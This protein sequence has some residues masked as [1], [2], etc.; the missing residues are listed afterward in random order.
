MKIA[1]IGGVAAGTSAAAKARRTDPDAEI[2]LFEKDNDISYAGC[3]LPYYI[4]DLIEER[5]A[6]V[7]NTPASFSERYNVDVKTGHEVTTINCDENI[8][9]VKDLANDKKIRYEYDK[10]IVA[11]GASPV[12]PPIPGIDLNNIFPLRTVSDADQI[13]E[14][15]LEDNI[16]KVAVIGA[17]LIGLEMVESFSKLAKD[18]SVIEM[19]P[20]VLPQF[21][22]EMA[23]IVEKHLQDKGVN[24]ILADGVKEFI[25]DEKVNK[26]ITQSGQEIEVD[27]VLLSIGVKPVVD[28]AEESGI[29]LGKTGAIAVDSK[30]QTSVEHIYA[31]GDCA[32]SKD[33]LTEKPVW[34]P[35]GSTANKQGRVAGENAAGGNYEHLG[36]LKTGITKIFD[37]TVATTGLNEEEAAENGFEPVSVKIRAHHHAGY[38]PGVNQLDIK[39]IFAK[40]TQRLL[41]AEII[42]EKGVDKRIDVLATAI[43]SKLTAADLFQIDLAYAPP[44]SSPKDPVAILGMVAE[45]KLS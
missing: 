19:Q 8:L 44:Y 22:N 34:V 32:E 2:V 17:G 13:K 16:K 3:G 9:F 27:L 18:V 41:G 23:E 40:K 36:I 37:L 43:F 31:A 42:G 30:M 29:K 35:L 5:E 25:G 7:V 15:A 28:L 4:S 12:V 39:A 10:L 6:I 14:K 45:K 20:H 21:S 11:T 26:V 1:V 33:L 38:Y 24:L